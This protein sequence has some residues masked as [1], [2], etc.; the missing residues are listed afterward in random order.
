MRSRQRKGALH[1]MRGHVSISQLISRPP[2]LS[3]LGNKWELKEA[4]ALPIDRRRCRFLMLNMCWEL[5]IVSPTGA[6]VPS[7][8]RDPIRSLDSTRDAFNKIN[9]RRRVNFLLQRLHFHILK[10]RDSPIAFKYS[11]IT[12]KLQFLF[13]YILLGRLLL[14]NFAE[15]LR[16]EYVVIEEIQKWRKSWK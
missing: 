1:N 9:S 5:S 16:C 4:L 6:R 7:F 3:A 14:F 2:A 12:R 11:N 10:A 15:F 8:I 13:V